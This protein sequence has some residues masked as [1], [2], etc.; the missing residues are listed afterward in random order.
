MNEA[1]FK[2]KLRAKIK[3]H[4]YIQSMSSPA[5]AG[6]PDLWL[7]GKTDLWLE[8]KYDEKTKGAVTPKLSPLQSRWLEARAK[9]GRN[10]AVI[11]GTSPSVAILYRTD[12]RTPSNDRRPLESIITELL[13]GLL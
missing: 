1:G 11:V 9:E 2:A 7:S 10:V 6:T 13:E 3:P 5:V 12:W 4:C 8:V